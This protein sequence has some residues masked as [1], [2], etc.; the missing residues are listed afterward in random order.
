[1]F[2]APDIPPNFRT[3]TALATFIAL[4]RDAALEKGHCC[5]REQKSKCP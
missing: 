4:D 3:A 5:N 1:M 2:K